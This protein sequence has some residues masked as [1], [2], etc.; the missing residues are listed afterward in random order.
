M[1]Q[2]VN[3]VLILEQDGQTQETWSVSAADPGHHDD[4]MLLLDHPGLGRMAV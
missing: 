2:E 3:E 1:I 4:Q